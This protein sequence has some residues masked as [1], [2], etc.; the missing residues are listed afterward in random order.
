VYA[1]LVRLQMSAGQAGNA[2]STAERLRARSY[3]DL[4]ERDTLDAGVAGSQDTSTLADEI[5]L[6]ERIRQLRKVINE[7][8]V[9]PAGERRQ[10][11]ISVY[12]EELIAAERA[13]EVLLD[14][15]RRMQS[16]GRSARAPAYE[17]VRQHL[18]AGEGLVEY[19]VG[20]GEVRS[21]YWLVK[22]HGLTGNM[23]R[24]LRSGSNARPDSASGGGAAACGQPGQR[25]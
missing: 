20:E 24:P 23:G 7:E 9:L 1:D 6:R 4:V 13:Y 22:D 5:E 2:F 8:N 16:A 18:L 21:S 12:S 11:A 10:P 25:G 3:R 15:R 19:V 17:E 14:D